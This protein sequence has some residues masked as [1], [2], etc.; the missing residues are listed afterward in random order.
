VGPQEKFGVY[1]ISVIGVSIQ[2]LRDDVRFADI[3]P[4]GS[5]IVFVDANTKDL[6]LMNADGSQAHLFIKAESGSPLYDPLWF[7]NGRRIFY[8]KYHEE[9]G[10]LTVQV[11]SCKTDASDPVQLLSDSNL[12]DYSRAQPGR[13]ILAVAE[14][15]P[16]E[17]NSNLWEI[18]YDPNS[19]KPKG[20]ERR[21]TDWPDFHFSNV[22]LT[23][24]G[25]TLAFLNMKWLSNVYI[26]KLD[27]TTMEQPQGI[28]ANQRKN[29]PSGWSS[30][31]K[32][33]LFYSD[34]AGGAFDL[35]RQGL[36]SHSPDKLATGPDDR[37]APQL[38]PDGKWILYM[39]WPK[40][41]PGADPPP[42]KLMRLPSAGGPAEFVADLK[43]HPFAG[44]TLG[45]FP[46]FHC[47]ASGTDCILAEQ[48]GEKEITFTWFDPAAGRKNE[49][50]KFSGNDP[51]FLNW[52]VSPD[53]SQIAVAFFDY[54]TGDITI[55]PV[56]GGAPQKVSLLPIQELGPIAWSADGKSFFVSSFSSR[57]SSV[58]RFEPGKTPVLLWKTVWDVRT[59]VPSP[60]GQHLAIGPDI[61]DANAWIIPNF[62]VR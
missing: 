4:D 3:S 20:A 18:D 46:S 14:A 2:K 59:L 8:V 38:T 58:Y 21:L 32:S 53:G 13:L 29:W 54:K 44:T 57:G 40:P 51:Y 36:D 30:D 45:G 25:N 33:I 62:P 15:P 60:D 10:K 12:R 24:D 7:S 22:H 47:P 41:A 28:T 52:N 35:Y 1:V 27:G 5:Q 34:L 9:N 56:K 17:R 43:G 37:W 31:S 23:A 42:G 55:L 61:Y 50:T 16:N 39:S 48:S 26:G 6:W 49:I 11:I 19:G